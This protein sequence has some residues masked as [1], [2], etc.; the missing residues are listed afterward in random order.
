[1]ATKTIFMPYENE[2]ETGSVL[3][4]IETATKHIKNGARVS[5]YADCEAFNHIV[6]DGILKKW[7]E[8]GWV[9]AKG[10]PIKD[11]EKWRKAAYL[12]TTRGFLVIESDGGYKKWMI[13][14][15]KRRETA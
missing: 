6:K 10:K 9:N 13:D 8:N 3:L 11:V 14:E 2:S 4:S 5:L 15:L 7:A 1:M 12:L